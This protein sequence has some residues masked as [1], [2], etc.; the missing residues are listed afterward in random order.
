[1]EFNV[2]SPSAQQLLDSVREE[3]VFVTALKCINSTISES[4]DDISSHSAKTELSK[5]LVGLPKITYL[6]ESTSFH[7]NPYE[8]AKKS[9]E[10]G[11]LSQGVRIK[12]ETPMDWRKYS[13]S[14]R[15]IRYKIQAW[16]GLD[17]VLHYDSLEG[18]ESM[19]KKAFSHIMDWINFFILGENEDDFS[20]YDMAV[21]QRASKLAYTIRRAIE[22]DE[23]MEHIAAM[24][25]CAE[26]HLRE[27]MDEGKIAMHS[28]HGLFQMAGLLTLGKSLPFLKNSSSASNFAIVNIKSM[29]ENHFSED[30]LH[31]EHSPMYHIFMTNYLSILLDSG[32]MSDSREFVELAQ[33]AITAASWFA[34]P[35]GMILPFG[36]TPNIPI[37]E[38]TNFQLNKYRNR[39]CA[40]IGLK[41]F[42][43]GGLVVH[44]HYSDSKGPIG[45]LAFNGAFHS[46]QH[47]HA[48]DFNIQ[49]FANGEIILTDPATFTYQYDLPERMYIESTRAHNCLEIDGLNYSRFRKDAY[50][51]AIQSVEQLGDFILI[52]AEVKRQRLVSGLVPNNKIKMD[53]GVKISLLHRRKIIYVPGEFLV[54][55]DLISSQKS[56]N[57]KQWFQFNPDLKISLDGVEASLFDKD[58]KPIA[59]VVSLSPLNGKVELYSGVTMPGLQGWISADGH[60]L[61]ASS[62]LCVEADGKKPVLATFFDFK[63]SIDSNI[64]FNQGTGGKYLRFS[65][66]RGKS[67]FEYVSRKKAA[68]T[69]ITVTDANGEHS[70]SK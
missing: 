33:G 70:L 10:K 41:T 12:L 31:K 50:G 48:D 47:K 36:D 23:S 58:D 69:E 4:K 29:L 60:S 49:L 52:D 17:A 14:S 13:E 15:S 45:Y 3:D 61:Q 21:G 24:I 9:I 18:D 65:I 19:F 55:L 57:Y 43:Q 2:L 42:E 39:A 67:V 25:V 66:K 32:F 22:N 28:N 37:V 46:R 16:G 26:I 5:L 44:S 35:N 54:V 34:Q 27:L 53:D 56:H 68:H 62:S 63:P 51:S 8:S 1:M 30:F 38:R 59:K 20:W 11:H 40:P 64:F 7:S 6:N